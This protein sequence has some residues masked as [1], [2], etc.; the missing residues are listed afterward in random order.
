MRERYVLRYAPEN[1][2]RAGWHKIA[3]RLKGQKGEVRTRN[4]YWVGG[5]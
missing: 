2:T 3:L 4:G 1:V 5:K